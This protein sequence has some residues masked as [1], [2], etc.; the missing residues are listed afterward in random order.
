MTLKTKNITLFSLVYLISFACLYT[1]I[2]FSDIRGF[3]L[4]L[5]LLS[6]FNIPSFLVVMVLYYLNLKKMI[7]TNN[8]IY[9]SLSILLF[10][11][12]FLIWNKLTYDPKN[13]F[14]IFKE[15]TYMIF[16]LCIVSH[17]ISLAFIELIKILKKKF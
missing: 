17:I 10:L 12:T 7:V 11:A 3:L 2:F 8:L 15:P 16:S 6:F 5:I 13:I 4:I 9:I 1:C 14:P